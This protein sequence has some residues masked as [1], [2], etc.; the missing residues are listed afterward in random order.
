MTATPS[1]EP[2]NA[3]FPDPALVVSYAA[4]LRYVRHRL[5]AFP[6]GQL[7]AWAKE[8][9]LH[10]TRLVEL[11]KLDAETQAPALQ[12][13]LAAFGYATEILRIILHEA[14]RHFFLFRD[15][16]A[17]ARFKAELSVFDTLPFDPL[18]PPTSTTNPPGGEAA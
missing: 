14:R 12:R 13:L 9:Q 5:N 1:A 8:H 4:V 17:L 3:G 15:A 11:K 16:D 7:K 10:Y 6:H 2:A 18:L